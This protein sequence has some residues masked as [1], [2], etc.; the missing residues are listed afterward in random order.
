MNLDWELIVD[1]NSKEMIVRLDYYKWS[2]K[3][4]DEPID[5][6]NHT[7]DPLRWIHT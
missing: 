7:I 3:K 4:Q 6:F 1:P 2:D 5:A